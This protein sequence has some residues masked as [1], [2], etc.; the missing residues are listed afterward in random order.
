MKSNNGKKMKVGASN[1]FVEVVLLC[2]ILFPIY[3]LAERPLRFGKGGSFKI[4]QVADMHYG[5]GKT[6]P[7][8]DV[9]SY[10]MATCSDL[11]TTAFIKRMILAEKPDL[12]V[13]TGTIPSFLFL[14]IITSFC[15]F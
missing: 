14:L 3:G 10:Q 6:T 9:F 5:D 15:S 13:F 4:L 7:C 8:G 1:F 12:I 11:N 2:L